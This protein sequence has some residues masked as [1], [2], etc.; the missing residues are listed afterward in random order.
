M[1][2]LSPLSPPC[3]H[4]CHHLQTVAAH[5]LS[6]LSPPFGLLRAY[7]RR[8]R[9][10]SLRDNRLFMESRTYGKAKVVV[11]VVTVVTALI[12]F[13]FFVSPLVTTVTTT[14]TGAKA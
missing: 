14:E 7:T 13:M 6:P 10:L 12:L 5:G 2:V 3:H 8:A 4:C 9:A 11:T 1:T